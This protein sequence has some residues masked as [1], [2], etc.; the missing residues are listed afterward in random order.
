MACEVQKLSL[1]ACWKAQDEAN[2]GEMR[3]MLRELSRFR[4]GGRLDLFSWINGW[5]KSRFER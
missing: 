1:R 3:P 2:R 4:S 5:L